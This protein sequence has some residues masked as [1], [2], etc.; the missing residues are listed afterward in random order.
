MKKLLLL[1]FMATALLACNNNTKEGA[2]QELQYVSGVVFDATMN[3]ITIVNGTDTLCFST[4]NA[5][6]DAVEGILIGDSAKI[7][8]TGD[9]VNGVID[10]TCT[11]TKCVVTP[12]SVVGSWVEPIPGMSGVQGFKLDSNGVASS[13][14]MSTLVYNSWTLDKGILYLS[15]ESIGNGQKDYVNHIWTIIT[16]S[17]DSLIVSAKEGLIFRY[18]RMK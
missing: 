3:T 15:G 17:P 5:Q 13:I 8:Y 1:T 4:E 9:L 6:K 18:A 12:V 11:V 16:L 14:N 7:F 2:D 10:Q